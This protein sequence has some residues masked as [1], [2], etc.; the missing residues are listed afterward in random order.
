MPR[1][2]PGSWSIAPLLLAL[3]APALAAEPWIDPDPDPAIPPRRLG[4]F[5]DIGLRGGAEY[6]AQILYVNP[7]SL[8]G[9]A[10]RRISSIDHRLRLDGGADYKDMV[11]ISTSVDALSGVLWGDNGDLDKA[12]PP[13]FGANLNTRN[14]NAARTCVGYREGDPLTPE[15]YGY[16][17]CPANDLFV[18]RAYG[19]IVTPIGLFRIGRQAFTEGMGTAVADGDGRTNRF[20]TSG[21]GNNVD[22]V[23]FATK[24]LEAFAPKE[25]RDTSTNRGL[26]LIVRYD[27]LVTDQLRFFADDLHNTLT[28]LRYLAPKHPLGENLELR[29]AHTYRWDEA[30]STGIH[31][32]NARATSSFGRLSAGFDATLVAGKT[33]EVSAAYHV[34]NNDPIVAQDVLQ[35]GA[36]AVVR[37]DEEL[38]TAYLEFDYASGD[39]D[40][41]TRSTLSQFLFAED[42]NVGLLL[43][44]QILA[45]QTARAAAAGVELLTRLGAPS[46]P[47]D[48]ISTRGAFTNAIALFPQIDFRPH[49]T[50]L[51][52]AGVLTAWAAEKVIDPVASLRRKDG[53]SVDDDLVNFVGGKPGKFYGV[54]LDARARWRFLDHFALDVEGAAFFPGDAL[55]D[56]NGDAV[57]SF[58]LQGR[59]TFFF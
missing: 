25:Q 43:F 10:D 1:M 16:A 5:S 44:D 30:N 28:A 38:W 32:V 55:Q 35:L 11:R 9:V 26:F 6:R 45:F 58:L 17:L 37:Y 2:K 14:V 21:T 15:A 57:Q 23:M 50:V 12:P 59:T 41:E 42:A 29:L 54:E 7:I 13:A 49:R 19:E 22:G 27:R 3:S 39:P 48:S 8:N 53:T 24:P 4:L 33:R 20:G 36:R 31:G 18:R 46:L 34:I 51:L 56:E 40:P 52:R 47:A